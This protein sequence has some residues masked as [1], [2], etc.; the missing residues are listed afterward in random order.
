MNHLSSMTEP[1][2]AKA[3]GMD[4]FVVWSTDPSLVGQRDPNNQELSEALKGNLVVH[5]GT[6]G[7]SDKKQEHAGLDVRNN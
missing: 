5:S 4:G 2:R 3:Y 6:L 1:V 7:P